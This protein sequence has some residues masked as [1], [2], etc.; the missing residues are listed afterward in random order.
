MSV[1]ELQLEIS[2]LSTPEIHELRDWLDGLSDSLREEWPED[3]ED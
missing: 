2:R 3:Y 1:A